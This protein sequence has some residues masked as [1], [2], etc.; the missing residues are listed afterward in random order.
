MP[1]FYNAAGTYNDALVQNASIAC[2]PCPTG[3][4]TPKAGSDAVSDCQLCLPGYGGVNCSQPCGGVAENATYG[5]L[6]RAYID[7]QVTQCQ[8][9]S[10]NGQTATY[11]F[12][13]QMENDLFTPKTVSRIGAASP[14]ECLS[15]YSQINDGSYYLP[16]SAT[17]DP[18][19]NT[20]FKVP[21][22]PNFAACIAECDSRQ[23]QLV[24]YDYVAKDCYVHIFLAP[25]YEG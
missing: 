1:L 24:T 19:G 16:I 21:N 12:H 7:N 9:C 13:F 20:V 5:P 25:K 2:K 3:R 4:T 22:T 14:I 17:E 11:S 6:G 23:C 15:E 10:A 18:S 8:S